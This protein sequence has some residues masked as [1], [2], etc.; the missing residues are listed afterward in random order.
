VQL[1]ELQH[2]IERFERRGVT[3]VA[4]SVDR[5]TD[6]AA[7]VQRLGITFPVLSDPDQKVI[8]AFRVQNPDTRELAIH[9]V[10]ILDADG[11]IFYRKVGRR[12][13]VSRE[14]IDAIDAYRGEY[15]RND[16]AVAPGQR[17]AV[18]YPANDFQALLTISRVDGLPGAVDPERFD[19]V[20]SAYRTETSD[21][22]L[23]AFKTLIADAEDA[24][25]SE[26]LDTAAWLVRLRFFPDGGDP[27]ETGTL[28]AWR[29]ERIRELET[30]LEHA[31]DEDQEDELLHTLARARAGLAMTRATIGDQAAAWNLRY[32]KTSLRSLREVV[33][34][35]VRARLPSP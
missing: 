35:E 22:A 21:D 20:L 29:L 13:P 31:A 32:V 34:A 30:A 25:E 8:G 26:L 3:V 7:M 18:A 19:A 11:T 1:G 14:L 5:P 15:P 17:I 24:G 16:E 12:R 23:I 10:Y 4:L 27:I 28:L 9:A 2:Q 33:H 6:S